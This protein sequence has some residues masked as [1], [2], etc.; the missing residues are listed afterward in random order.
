MCSVFKNPSGYIQSWPV[1][2][3]VYIICQ[4]EVIKNQAECLLVAW[5]NRK[6]EFILFFLFINAQENL[7]CKELRIESNGI[8]QFLCE[9]GTQDFSLHNSAIRHLS[10]S[11]PDPCSLN[12]PHLIHWSNIW[13]E[14]CQ[15]GWW[16][17]MCPPGGSGGGGV[18]VGWLSE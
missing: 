10:L 2:F 8:C 13:D 16:F 1:H 5:L 17:K 15:T 6:N 4:S 9:K 3:S 14:I 18:G 7:L 11:P 12:L